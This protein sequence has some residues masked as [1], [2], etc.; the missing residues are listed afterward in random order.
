MCVTG[1]QTCALP[2][3]KGENEID[4][5]A[6]DEINRKADFYEVKRNPSKISLSQLQRKVNVFMA[7]THE[8]QGYS[9]A[10]HG[11][12]MDDM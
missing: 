6:V 2:I 12:S 4:I 7:G 10:I 1:V 9:V 8:L 11:L 3:C 5:I